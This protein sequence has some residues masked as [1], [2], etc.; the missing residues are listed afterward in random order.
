MEVLLLLIVEIKN[1]MKK[2]TGLLFL[3]TL[4]QMSYAQDFKKVQ[5]K[6]LLQK[7]EAAKDEYE[8]VIVKKG[9]LATTSEGVYL[10]AVI[11]DGLSKDYNSLRKYPTAYDIMHSSIYEYMKLDGSYNETIV[12]GQTPFF[13]IYLKSFKDGVANF[14]D[15]EWKKAAEHFDEAVKFSDLIFTRR[16][17]ASQQLF[18]TTSLMYAGYSHQNAG[19]KAICAA[20]YKRLIDAKINS[21]ELID[22]YRY[23]LVY[24]IDTKDKSGFEKYYKITQEAYPTENW[25][26]YKADFIDKN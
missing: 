8:D 16:W 25:L 3:V 2:I 9:T 12:Y 20:Y 23:L 14:S 5:N 4:T 11:Y 6:L 13:T 10:K 24:Y 1:F 17:T 7:Y 18:D 21:S 26:E 22:A 19:N 15:K